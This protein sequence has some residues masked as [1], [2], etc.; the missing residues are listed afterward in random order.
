MD[1]T[2]RQVKVYGKQHCELV[3]NYTVEVE[4]TKRC[5]ALTAYTVIAED[6]SAKEGY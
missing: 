5:S 6:I 3:E 4:S 1:N 2:I